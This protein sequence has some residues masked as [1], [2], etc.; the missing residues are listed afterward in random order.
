M[1]KKRCPNQKR[2]LLSTYHNIASIR[3]KPGKISPGKVSIPP[4]G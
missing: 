3:D 4:N 1:A 2:E